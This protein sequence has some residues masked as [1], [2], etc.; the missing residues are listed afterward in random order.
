MKTRGA[1]VTSVPGPYD[2]VEMDVDMPRVGEIML[3]MVASGLC[4]SDEHL[5]SGDLPPGTLPMCGGH[6]GAGIVVEVGPNTPGWAKGD[7]VVLSCLPGCGRCR[8]CATGH[9]NLCEVSDNFMLGSRFDDPSS[10]RLSWQGKPVGQWCGIGTFCEYAT[11]SVL[12][13]VK[14]PHAIPLDKACLIGCGVNTGWGAAVNSAEVK[15]GQTVIIMGC[16]GVGSFAVQGASHAGALNI[17]AVDP[18]KS[19]RDY[20]FS[21]GATHG[22]DSIEEATK[23]AKELTGGHGADA[24][25]I[26]LGTL[27]PDHLKLALDSVGKNGIVVCTAL[28]KSTDV[29]FKLSIFDLT[30]QQKRIQGSMFGAVSPSWDILKMVNMYLGGRLKLDGAISQT[31]TLDQ[32][33][34]GYAD[35]KTGKNIRGAIL[36]A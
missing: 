32:V 34:Q 1:I 8:Y 5:T 14:V 31:Y 22:C 13:A 36:F 19:K 33:N 17:I 26:T 6:E 18:V 12:S 16:G 2:I 27:R 4:L 21:V 9:Q 11:V 29:D 25:A 3:K 15:P 23:L 24:T 7:H 30:L 20:A 10:Y 28:G 35:L